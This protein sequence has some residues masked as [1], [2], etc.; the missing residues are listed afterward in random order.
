[1]RSLAFITLLAACQPMSPS[2]DGGAAQIADFTLLD[3]NP[4]SA[5]ANQM[6]T[7]RQFAGHVSGWYFA[8]SS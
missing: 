8:H 2:V 3:V 6:V 1:M 7:P 5:T 4:A